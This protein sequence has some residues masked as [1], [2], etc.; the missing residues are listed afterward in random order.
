MFSDV[1]IDYL[2]ANM[3]KINYQERLSAKECLNKACGCDLGVPLAQPLR[4]RSVTPTEHLPTS[5]ILEAIQDHQSLE[6]PVSSDKAVIQRRINFSPVKQSQVPTE[7]QNR[8]DYVSSSQFPTKRRRTVIGSYKGHRVST[9][10]LRASS[11][12]LEA[13]HNRAV[14]LADNSSPERANDALEVRSS[15]GDHQVGES[16]ALGCAMFI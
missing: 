11:P 14:D 10:F 12:T 3:L 5:I 2:S 6:N 1:L 4:T 16:I 15:H 7:A 8:E 9:D 13:L